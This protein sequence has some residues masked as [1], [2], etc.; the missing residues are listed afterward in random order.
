M[1]FINYDIT[2]QEYHD[3]VVLVNFFLISRLNTYSLNN[4]LLNLIKI[5]LIRSSN[6]NVRIPEI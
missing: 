3:L 5:S 1:K 6:Q 2:A 4:A